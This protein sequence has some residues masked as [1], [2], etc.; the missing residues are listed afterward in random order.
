MDSKELGLVVALATDRRHAIEE[1]GRNISDP[2]L[3]NHEH[4]EFVLE[5]SRVAKEF[6]SENP[7][8]TLALTIWVLTLRA[9]MKPE[10]RHYGREIWGD[11]ERGFPFVELSALEALPIIGPL[12]IDGYDNFPIGFTPEPL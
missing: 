11:L 6:G 5:L 12:K 2:I 8:L 1:G 10:F 9:T 3:C 4:P 7:L